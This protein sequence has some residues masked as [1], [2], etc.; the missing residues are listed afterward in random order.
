MKAIIYCR[1]GNETTNAK[2]FLEMQRSALCEWCEEHH[3][4]IIDTVVE[5]Q[6]GLNMD[7]VGWNRVETEAKQHVVDMILV[8]SSSRI[9]RKRS[10]IVEAINQLK[11]SGVQVVSATEGNLTEL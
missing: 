11:R 5:Q 9:A 1:V 6:A 3:V 2:M 8:Q 10:D 4:E 7:R